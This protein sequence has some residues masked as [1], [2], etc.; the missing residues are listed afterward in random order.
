MPRLDGTGPNGRGPMSG[1][2]RGRCADRV[3]SRPF[4]GRARKIKGA[5]YPCYRPA[6]RFYRA[7]A[8]ERE[9]FLAQEKE[10]LEEEIQMVEE[11][12]SELQK[13]E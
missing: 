13:E 1:G 8:Q 11:E 3:S 6:R 5:G 2:G 12:L 9:E 4:Y 10:M 7:T